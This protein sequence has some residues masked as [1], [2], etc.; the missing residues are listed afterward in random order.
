MVEQLNQILQGICNWIAARNKV[1]WSGDK[2]TGSITVSGIDDYDVISVEINSY[3]CSV[4]M[5][6]NSYGSYIGIGTSGTKSQVNTVTVVLTKTGTNTY[7]V[8]TYAVS[9]VNSGA[10]SDISQNAFGITK[11]IG[12]EPIP[13]KIIGGGYCKRL[14]SVLRNLFKRRCAA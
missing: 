3:W 1:L 10:H 7:T 9:H 2:T 5:K 4:I 12:I 6:K 13:E 14:I 11:I 8:N